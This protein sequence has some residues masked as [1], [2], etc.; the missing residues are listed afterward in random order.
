MAENIQFIIHKKGKPNRLN[1]NAIRGVA[2]IIMEVCI[3][4]IQLSA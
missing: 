2:V 3:N 1:K 4:Y